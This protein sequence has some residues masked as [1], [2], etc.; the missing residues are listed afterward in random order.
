MVPA[1]RI[2]GGL[3]DIKILSQSRQEFP[4]SKYDIRENIQ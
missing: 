3:P 4:L 1:L 2:A